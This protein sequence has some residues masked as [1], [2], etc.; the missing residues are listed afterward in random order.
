MRWW[1]GNIDLCIRNVN[2]RRS[3]VKK[4]EKIDFDQ[5]LIRNDFTQTAQRIYSAALLL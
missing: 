1:V 5:S 4:M 3:Q 2:V